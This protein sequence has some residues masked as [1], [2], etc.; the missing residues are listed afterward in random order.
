[1]N[2]GR[3]IQFQPDAVLEKA[4]QL[5]WRQGYKGCSL[6]ALLAATG[7]SKSSLYNAFGGKKQLFQ[8]CLIRYRD[9]SVRHLQQHLENAESAHTFISSTLLSVAREPRTGI[10]PRGCFIMNTATE[11]AQCDGDVA[12]Q[13][14]HSL[15]LFHDRFLAAVKR[16]QQEGEM[17]QD[18]DAGT[19]ATYLVTCMGGLRTMVKGGAS[20]DEAERTVEIILRALQ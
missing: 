11:F 8:R 17:A 2:V 6:Q 4:M 1:M 16:G 7:L 5:F 12:R 13:V 18:I 10:G 20:V 14:D 15:A 19:L 9:Q 3:P